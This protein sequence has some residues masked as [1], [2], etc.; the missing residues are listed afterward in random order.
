MMQ[1]FNLAAYSLATYLKN[2]NN[3][4][5]SKR[6]LEAVKPVIHRLP[7]ELRIAPAKAL[8]I[9]TN[10]SELILSKERTG[11]HYHF[12]TGIHSTDYLTWFV[13][14]DMDDRSKHRSIVIFHLLS[15]RKILKLYYFHEI[16][17]PSAAMRIAYANAVIPHLRTFS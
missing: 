11:N 6:E 17:R 5:Y 7:N 9:A 8:R 3:S 16:D 14:N 13:G 12:M 1:T 4:Y 2:D 15:E 10:A